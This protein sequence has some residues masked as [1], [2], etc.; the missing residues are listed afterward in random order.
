MA[1]KHHPGSSTGRTVQSR[2]LR[3]ISR[4][5]DA[6]LLDHCQN[7]RP[8][9]IL[10]SP[11]MGKSSL[12]AHTAEQLN[13]A[14]YHAVLIDLSQFPLP[15]R[16]QE[17]FYN[18]VRILDNNLDLDSDILSWWEK[19]SLFALPPHQRLT[20]LISDV[21]L[22]EIS[23]PL[24][25]FIDEIERTIPLSFREHFFEWL[26]SLYESRAT[27]SIL[28]RFSFVVCGVATPT[29]LIP[30]GGPLIF[31]W[32]HHVKLS[33]FTLQ[34]AL[35][36]AEGLSLPTDAAIEAVEWVYAW[37]NG[38]PYLTQLLCRLLEEQ[39]RKTWHESEVDDCVRHFIVSPQGLREPNFQFIRT[40][41]TEPAANGTSLLE[42]YLELLEGNIEKLKNNPLAME[43][44][45]LV[46]VLRE[47]EENIALRNPLYL[48]VFPS[49][50]V[51]R[52]L[53]PSATSLSSVR[54]SHIL[55]ASF[56]LLGVGID[57]RVAFGKEFEVFAVVEFVIGFRQ[58]GSKDELKGGEVV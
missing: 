24:V 52:H 38:H 15:P 2:E 29:E 11:Q 54:P 10:H 44:L 55:A 37:T 33:D 17:W 25:L 21:I 5:A 58:P 57:G 8:A 47:D 18:I 30:E 39:H 13:A 43:Q 34:E 50:W 12:I 48:E 40:A 35:A 42:P 26:V 53:R 20:Q 4:P 19:P 28:Y 49:T 7:G 51:K 27:N 6:E 46:G 14:S 22:P 31:Q 16:E 9:Y 41:L 1:H 45:R 56:F 32:S 3:Y 23:G 36:L